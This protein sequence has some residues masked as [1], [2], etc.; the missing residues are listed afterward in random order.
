MSKKK[1]ENEK[2]MKNDH[3]Q[4]SNNNN[5]SGQSQEKDLH[6]HEIAKVKMQ[7]ATKENLQDTKDSAEEKYKELS[8][9]FMRLAAEYDNFRR[10]SQKEKEAIYSDCILSIVSSWL[11]VVDNLER[12]IFVSDNYNS[13]EAKQIAQGV[14][15]ILTQAKDVLKSLEVEEIQA[16]GNSFDPN[17][18]EAV[19]HV[20]DENAG[21]SE[22]LEV[23]SKGYIRK[24]K[25]VRHSV[26]KVAN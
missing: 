18:M 16:V 20:E 23:F 1:D 15:M 5:N 11:P 4:E 13:S 8:D 12:A 26:V 22:V 2:N 3:E 25:V 9:K 19:M 10:R 21:E 7:E 6:D 24:D 17:K 14:E